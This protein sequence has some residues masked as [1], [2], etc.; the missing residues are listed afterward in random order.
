M[1]SMPFGLGLLVLQYFAELA[2]L[3]TGR[4]LPFGLKPKEDVEEF[5]RA[6]AKQ[7]LGEVP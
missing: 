4:A 6:Q 3:V 1:L 7:A 2:C 5:A